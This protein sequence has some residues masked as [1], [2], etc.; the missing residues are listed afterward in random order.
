MKLNNYVLP[1]IIWLVLTIAPLSNAHLWAQKEGY[2]GAVSSSAVPAR[3]TENDIELQD[4]YLKGV[5]LQQ[6][7]K[8]EGAIRAFM[9]VLERDARNDA[10]AFQLARLYAAQDDLRHAI[11][12]AQKAVGFDPNNIWYKRL[13]GEFYERN[14]EFR[15]AAEIYKHLVVNQKHNPDE[16]IVARY[17]E[18]LSRIGEFDAA[19]RAYDDLE[20]IEGIQDE[21]SRKKFAICLTKKDYK[22]ATT[23]LKRLVARFPNRLDLQHILAEFYLSQG[24]YKESE[25]IYQQILAK[26]PKDKQANLVLAKK[27]Q[28][29]NA[30]QGKEAAYLQA[31]K[32]NFAKSEIVID[33]KI[34]ELLPYVNRLADNNKQTAADTK[35]AL[36]E[37]A[38]TLAQTHP[39]EAKAYAV[40][41]DILYQLGDLQEALTQYEKC[42]DLTK[43]VFAVWEQKMMIEEELGD[44]QAL[45]STSDAALE[46]YPN[47]ATVFFFH[48]LAAFYLKKDA[49]AAESLSQALMMTAKRPTLQADVMSLLSSVRARQQRFEEAE[50]LFDDA[51]KLAPK[52]GLIIL[53][54]A[55]TQLLRG[56][57]FIGYAEQLTTQALNPATETNPRVLELFGDCLFHKG[58]TARAVEY[59]QKAQ[60]YGSKSKALVRKIAEKKI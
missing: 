9:A 50:K 23:E 1:K 38:Q 15:K 52:S 28:L 2:Q 27:N 41:G 16:E 43:T 12:W 33:V 54:H 22:R 30:A 60:Q 25:A 18:N 31:L 35:N 51:T 40:Y 21:I 7:G 42:L 34:K 3:M 59:W 5:H 56:G 49:I 45:Q 37:L 46:L 58:D 29:A 36:I 53:R 6:L 48:G 19:L 26:N 13:L 39:S 44:Y 17:A 57:A 8:M 47:Q 32:P 4:N 55:L 11:E 24:Q 20:K 14:G 10:A